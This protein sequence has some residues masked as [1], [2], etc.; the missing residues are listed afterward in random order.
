MVIILY[1]M[2]E[3]YSTNSKIGSPA[4][5]FA[6]L[7]KAASQRPVE[8]NQD[9]SYTTLKSNFALVFGI[10]QLCSGSG[11]VFLDQAYWQ[12]AIASRP[13]TA[14]RAYILGGMA[15][16]AIPFGFA[17]TLGLAAVALTDNPDFPTYPKPM[18]ESQITAGLSAAFAAS[19]LLG[20]NGAVALLI[21][22]FMA[23]TSCASAELIAV[24]SILTFDV[25]KTYI[26]P[27]AS[28]ES[29]VRVAHINVCVFGLVMAVFSIIWQVIGIDLGWLFLVMGLLIGGAVFPVAFAITWKKQTKAGAI[30]GALVGLVAGITAWLV[31][32]KVYYGK[33]T[34]TTTGMEYPTLAGNLAAI[35]TGLI[36]TVVVSLIKPDDFD[37]EITRAINAEPAL[38]GVTP[39]DA[40]PSSTLAEEPEG[41]E[42]KKPAIEDGAPPAD[43]E[44]HKS[45]DAVAEENPSALRS[46][47]KLACI[48]AFVLPFVM[49]FL[50]PI[51]MF[52][53]HYVFSEGFFTAW[54]VISF[55]WV[56]SSAAISV[57]LPLWETASFFKETARAIVR[58]VRGG[59]GRGKA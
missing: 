9:G 35:M 19:T 10:I 55:I 42:E 37:W 21:T 54:V 22:L 31:E 18:S 17:T 50:I 30:S 44:R 39:G 26:K 14:V 59:K 41:P 36:V 13:A 38:E 51:P 15:W 27:S 24:S 1:F 34:V 8:G 53:S 46:A 57:V 29:L 40:S 5:M 7:K 28:P 4:A 6:L 16:F 12:R 43:L 2:F 56:F 25:Y 52:L 20:K 47:F 11:T 49:D 32:A 23:V 33:L 58:D 48:A 45:F 3:V